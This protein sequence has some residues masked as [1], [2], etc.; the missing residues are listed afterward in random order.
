[1]AR[2]R[3]RFIAGA[4]CPACQA[5]DTLMLLV[6]EKD[7]GEL[8]EQVQCVACQ[9][10]FTEKDKQSEAEAATSAATKAVHDD[11]VIGIFKP[12]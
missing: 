5:T 3:K 11:N 9:H 12:E 1:M 7:S 2:T 6:T 8:E 4:E 10:S